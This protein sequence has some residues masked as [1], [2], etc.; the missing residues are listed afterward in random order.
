MTTLEG[1]IVLVIGGT[2]GI[3]Y[4]VARLALLSGASQVIIASSNRAKVD[5]AISRLI[6]D[7]EKEVPS[8]RNRLKG[9]LFD[10]RILKEVQKLM[11]RVGEVD[12]VVWTAGEAPDP[13][14]MA[15][16]PQKDT[17]EFKSE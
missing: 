3:G 13:Q 10:A 14:M 6:V 16:P 4:G 1:Q 7:V 9:E 17:E 2:S 8:M 15:W 5:N 11:E 12:H